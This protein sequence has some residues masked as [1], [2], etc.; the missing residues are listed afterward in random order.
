MRALFNMTL[1]YKSMFR[2]F[3]F[4]SLF[5]HK[6]FNSDNCLNHA[7]GTG[8]DFLSWNDK[9]LKEGKKETNDNQCTSYFIE[10]LPWMASLLM[11]GNVEG[12]VCMYTCDWTNFLLDK[13]L[14]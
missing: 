11:A 7:P 9:L 12:K 1:C 13:L 2:F 14:N 8:E 3:L 6:L 4:Y 10:P 5:R